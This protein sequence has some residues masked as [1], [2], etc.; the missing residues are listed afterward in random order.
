MGMMGLAL[1]IVG[2]YGLVAYAATRRTREIGI[3]MA[4]GATRSTVLRMVLRRDSLLAL[5]GLVVGPGGERW[6]RELLQAAFPSGDDRQDIMALVLVA[7]VV[8]AVTC[9]AAYIPA[10]RASR[11]NPTEALRYE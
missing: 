3:R 6:R 11:I 4:I 10:R 8:L 1:S 7:P 5:A 9:L 2:L